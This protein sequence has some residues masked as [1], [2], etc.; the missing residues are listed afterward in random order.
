LSDDSLADKHDE[1]LNW[2]LLLFANASLGNRQDHNG[3]LDWKFLSVLAS[4]TAA[5]IVLPHFLH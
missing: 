2:L 1:I 5:L 3:L 4:P